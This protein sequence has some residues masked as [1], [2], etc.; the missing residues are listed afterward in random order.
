LIIQLFLDKFFMKFLLQAHH[1]Y[2][3]RLK[4][5]HS[6]VGIVMFFLG[7]GNFIELSA[8]DP[9]YSQFMFNQV[10][11]NP[12][13]AGSSPYPRVASGYRN[14]WPGIDKAYVSYYASYDQFVNWLDGGLGINISRDVQGKGVFSKTAMD[15][16]YSFPIEINGDL[17]VNFGIQGSLVQKKL[18]GASLVLPDQDPYQGTS[19]QE[20]I[21]DQSKLYPDF[22]AG[23]TFRIKEQY[24]INFSVYHL[25]TPNEMIGAEKFSTPVSYNFQLL[26]QFP[27][28]Q[29][30]RNEKK[31]TTLQPGL[32][33][34]LQKANTYFGWG[35]NISVA[36]FIG[37]LWLRNNFSLNFNT[38]I[39]LVGYVHSG[40]SLVYSYD[41]WVPK[42]DQGIKNYGAHEVTFAYLFQYNDPRKKMRIVKCPKF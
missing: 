10:C 14:Q 40:L 22:S 29:K 28:N 38:F 8:Q 11:F 13:F 5:Q 7:S 41:L 16:M 18:S 20:I 24:Q 2:Q 37:G 35:S 19:Q 9:V 23:T 4:F 27:G 30:N 26:G 34:Q 25:N 6:L 31:T 39:I 21:P 32:M 42:N 3:F 17:I 1:L 33:V 15:L 36:P 12:A